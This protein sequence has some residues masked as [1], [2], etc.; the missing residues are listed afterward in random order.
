MDYLVNFI[1]DNLQF[2]DAEIRAVIEKLLIIIFH[3]SEQIL[4]CRVNWK[5]SWCTTAM[6]T[7][8]I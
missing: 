8:L 3:L 1:R 6:N 2:S 5:A 4:T 7:T